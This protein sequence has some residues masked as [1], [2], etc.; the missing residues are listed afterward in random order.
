MKKKEKRRKGGEKK[1]EKGR[2]EERKKGKKKEKGPNAGIEP[3]PPY[4]AAHHQA[5]T[6]GFNCMYHNSLTAHAPLMNFFFVLHKLQMSVQL[7]YLH[8]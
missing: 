8:K 4:F 7:C 5:T 6:S 3:A 1:G 2:K